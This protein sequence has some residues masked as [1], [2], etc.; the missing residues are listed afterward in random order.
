MKKIH[1]HLAKFGLDKNEI[2]VYL[3]V[4]QASDCSIGTIEKSTKLHR[5]LIYNAANSLEAKNLLNIIKEGGRRRFIAADPGSFEQLAIKQLEQS[6]QLSKDLQN[7]KSGFGFSADAR[8]HKGSVEIRKYYLESLSN[9]PMRSSVFILGV[10][11][12]R[13]FEIFPKD[14]IEFD[15][16][17]KRRAERRISW[18]LLLSGREAEESVLNKGRTLLKCRR[19]SQP[20]MAPID[21]VVWRDRVGILIYGDSPSILDIPGAKTAKGF[22]KYFSLLWDQGTDININ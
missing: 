16:L 19:I 3:A 10:N 12:Q 21:L 4:L 20:I 14:S 1:E 9:Q 5:Q 22:S 18:R 11:S 15:L 2:I 7:L 6:R 13:F 17:E 8:L